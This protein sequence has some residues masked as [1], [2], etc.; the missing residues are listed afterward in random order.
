MGLFEQ[1]EIIN[2]MKNWIWNLILAGE[3]L[4][5]ILAIMFVVKALLDTPLA[6]AALVFLIIMAVAFYV[7]KNIR[8]KRLAKK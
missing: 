3:A 4:I 2:K 7:T 1:K 8:E 5:G 6:I